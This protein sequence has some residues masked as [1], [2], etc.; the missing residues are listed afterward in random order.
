MRAAHL[1]RPPRP[2]PKHHLTL[3]VGSI[4][5]RPPTPPVHHPNNI[6]IIITPTHPAHHPNTISP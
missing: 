2:P 5:T 1:P 3:K 4:M 6:T